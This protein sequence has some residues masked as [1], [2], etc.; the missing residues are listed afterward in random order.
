[1]VRAGRWIGNPLVEGLRMEAEPETQDQVELFET[2]MQ[3]QVWETE[4]QLTMTNGEAQELRVQIQVLGEEASYGAE[5]STRARE[6][7]TIA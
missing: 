1:M 7:R 4:A 2:G 3:G 5:T 6:R